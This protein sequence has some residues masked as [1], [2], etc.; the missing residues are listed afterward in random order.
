LL[1]IGGDPLSSEIV[2][3][4]LETFLPSELPGLFV[5]SAMIRSFE[6]AFEQLHARISVKDIC[7]KFIPAYR[8]LLK[9][10][11]DRSFA[12]NEYRESL[13]HTFLKAARI[14]E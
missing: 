14:A 6:H 7:T 11:K 3:N 12:P 4:R 5:N 13:K 10:I 9:I 8:I 1:D 2:G